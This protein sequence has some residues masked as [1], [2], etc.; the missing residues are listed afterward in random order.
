MNGL[1]GV[2]SRDSRAHRHRLCVCAPALACPCREH[3]SRAE[4]L[5]PRGEAEYVD[6]EDVARGRLVR[7]CRTRVLIPC[8]ELGL[9][10]HCDGIQD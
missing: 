10:G 4:A 6:V 3:N 1:V 8:C 7:K 5:L 2:M 9:L